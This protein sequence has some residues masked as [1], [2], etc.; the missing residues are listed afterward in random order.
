METARVQRLTRHQHIL[1]RIGEW[2]AYAES[3]G[4]FA[5]RAARAAEGTLSAKS[6]GRFSAGALA[7]MS[8]IFA[9]EAAMKV[10][11]EGIR[12]IGGAAEAK[13][14][15]ELEK[16][17]CISTVYAAQAG[18]LADMDFVADILYGRKTS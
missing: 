12:W 16:K 9:R 2:T 13:D 10:G 6:H 4:A 11:A 1:F 3:A 5:R 14:G 15:A 17:L 8:R 7:A 18:L